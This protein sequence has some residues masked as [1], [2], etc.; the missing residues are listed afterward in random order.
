MLMMTK[1]KMTFA[2]KTKITKS[3]LCKMKNNSAELEVKVHY[4]TNKIEL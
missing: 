2:V 3:R 1:M 4:Q